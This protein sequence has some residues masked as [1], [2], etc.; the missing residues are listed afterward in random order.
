MIASS[1]RCQRQ[2]AS[3]RQRGADHCSGQARARQ[4]PNA[5]GQLRRSL[6]AIWG[7]VTGKISGRISTIGALTGK[8]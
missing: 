3:S 8:L 1:S 7:S 2:L 4:E 5:K 6:S